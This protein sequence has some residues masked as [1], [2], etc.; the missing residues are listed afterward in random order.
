MRMKLSVKEKL[1]ESNS[2]RLVLDWLEANPEGNRA[3][4]SREVCRRLDLRDP[5]GDWQ[6]A[7][8][9]KALRDLETQGLWRLPQSKL[10]GPR[11]WNPNRLHQAVDT[12]RK[13]PKQVER[14]KE[15]KLV[16]VKDP[17]HLRIWNELVIS[18]HPLR[19]CRL[20]GRQ[21]RYLIGSAHGWL[22]AIGFG[23]AALH[24]ESRDSWIGWN[25]TL[26]VEHLQ[27]V[28]NMTRFLI[29]PKL[30]CKNLASHVLGLCARRVAKD[31]ELRYGLRPW[32][33][34][35]FVEVPTY[36]GSC[37][38]GA[39]WIKVGQTKGRGRN[40]RHDEGK[41]LKD[42]YLYPL[43]GDLSDRIGV[44][45]EPL[46]PLDVE[47]GLDSQSWAEQEFGNCQLG[48]KRLNRRLVKV[49]YQQGAQPSGSYSQ[50]AGGNR[51]D[52]KGYY[53]LFNS[54]QE[55]MGVE[56]ILQTHRT[57]TLRRMQKQDVVLAI[58]D[59]TDMNLSTRIHCEGLGQVGTN[60]TGAI[61]R[62]LKL[63]SSI[64][65]A[66]NGLPLGILRL[67]GY[68][69]ESAKGKDPDRPIQE[70]DSYRWLETYLDTV[71]AATE[72]INTQVVCVCDREGDI[73][74]LFDLRRA[75]QRKKV[76]LLVRA[77]WDRRL[78]GTQEK[79]FEE[80]S[81][82]PCVKEVKIHVP[83]QREHQ[84]KPSTPGRPA[85]PAREA[86]VEVRFK[87]VTISPPQT[88]QTRN[89]QPIKLFAV[90]ILEK[91]PPQGAT[92]VRWMLLTTLPI[93]S[94]KEALKCLRWYC[95]RWR[96]EE[97][98]RVLK[99]GCKILD[100]QNHTAQVLLR[101]IAL[102]AVIAWRIMLLAL[103]GREVPEMPCDIIF[104][105]WERGV[106]ELLA[107]KKTLDGRSDD[108]PGQTGRLSQS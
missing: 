30:R 41:S 57:Q 39:N 7:T 56:S 79:L 104:N 49:A 3:D 87:E 78:E 37:Y 64:A 100:H 4:L 97:W 6:M 107:Q 62:G 48:D 52:L 83:R 91:N 77:S 76:D 23:S 25:P 89:R 81:Q 22:G 15:L 102:D 85:L 68:A 55:E 14:I 44:E 34:E 60:Q 36:Q 106:L 75:Q 69:P 26:R 73:F 67:H 33:L 63:H 31:Y 17:E 13:V 1:S 27:R 80:L 90:Y 50:A 105:K 38:Q 2:V 9:S 43:V 11:R 53:R 92:Q 58:Q 82:T 18:E 24:M 59:T 8:T 95:L 46:S 16:E 101:T 65:V 66:T 28:I 21:L 45:R 74:E 29:R 70:K 12:P 94:V 86:Q 40:G 10:C 19:D 108:H 72:L 5:K 35:S 54:K 98:H 96:I 32:L 20:V 71:E 47:S 51:H 84:S 103:L 88:S 42:V 99:S 61:S 93:H